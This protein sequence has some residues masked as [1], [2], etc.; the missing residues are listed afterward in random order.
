MR[1]VV[2]SMEMNTA[3]LLV[4]CRC[5]LGE[6]LLWDERRR[7]L[8]WA[9][10]QSSVLWMHWI[11]D[12]SSLHW[13]LPDRLG[14]IAL[15]TSGSVLLGLAKGLFLV[16]VDGSM[17]TELELAKLVDVEPDNPDT[18][19]N[20]CSTDRSGAFV[21]GTLHEDHKT[22]A[23]SFY[24]Y[25]AR[26]GLR[27]LDLGGVAIPNSICFSIDGQTM[28]FCDSSLRRIMRCRYD[29]A[30]ASVAD[31]RVFAD[32]G[33]EQGTPDGSII[34]ADGFLWNAEWGAASARRYAPNGRIDRSVGLAAKNPTSVALGGDDLDVL[35]I[36]SARKEMSPEELSRTPDAGGVYRAQLSGVR[37]LPEERFQDQK[38]R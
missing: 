6:G 25:S 7:A 8:L 17:G 4:D 30:S 19:I 3:T 32:F 5:V 14:A 20:D 11:D 26:H 23:G 34:D 1:P 21:F 27:R 28:Y 10:I 38:L 37:G 16:D 36:T 13:K 9:D 18:R 33:S 15:C 31:I 35:F 24:Q 2:W 12:G 22:P 29:S